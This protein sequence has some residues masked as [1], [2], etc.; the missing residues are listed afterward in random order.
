MTRDVAIIATGTANTASVSAAF[1]RCGCTSRIT[2]DRA[3]VRETGRVVLPGVGSFEA[4][5][6]AL[7][8][9]GLEETLRKRID[10]GGPV[11]AI[12]L[13]MQLLC[14]GSDESPGVEGLGV[15]DADVRRLDA[16]V[17]V[18]QFGWNMVHRG[19]TS[20]PDDGYAYYANSFCLANAPEGWKHATT[21]YG[22]PFVAA[23]ERGSLLACQFHPE[24]SGSWGARLLEGWLSRSEAGIPC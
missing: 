9:L 12:C 13:G 21:T 20:L 10:R 19:N 3:E 11:L 24:L 15:I 17:R 14:S 1:R 7:R 6:A 16:D 8:S 2:T 5:M 4:G 23:I 22:S 18:P